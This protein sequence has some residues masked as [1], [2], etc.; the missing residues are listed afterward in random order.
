[1][2]YEEYKKENKEITFEGKKYAIIEYADL[3]TYEQNSR[4]MVEYTARALGKDGKEY[5]VKW[6]ITR[7]FAHQLQEAG[8]MESVDEQDACFWDNPTTVEKL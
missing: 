6:E 7:E 4:G 2:T 8:I 5:Y 3:Y 1:M